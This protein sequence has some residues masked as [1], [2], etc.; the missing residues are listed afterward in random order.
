M[1][2]ENPTILIVEDDKND[3]FLIKNAFQN[4][5]V[6]MPVRFVENGREAIAYLNGDG[7]YSDR[8]RY[9]FPTTIITDLKMPFMD[10]FAVLERRRENPLWAIIPVAVLSASADLDDI[11]RA[12]MLGAAAYHVKPSN[13]ME[14]RRILKLF[15]DYWCSVEIPLSDESGEMLPTRSEG[16]LGERFSNVEG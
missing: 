10:G 9:P 12:Y 1:K 15:V 3:Q 2:V 7:I 5:G 4:I 13:P 8:D 16:K 6:Q 11:K 14:L